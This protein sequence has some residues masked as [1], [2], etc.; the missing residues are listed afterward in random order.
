MEDDENGME[1]RTNDKMN[2][3]NKDGGMEGGVVEIFTRWQWC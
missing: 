3:W 2:E 1:G